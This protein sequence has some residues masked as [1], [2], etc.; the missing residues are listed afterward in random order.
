MKKQ[1]DIKSL[2]RAGVYVWEPKTVKLV[3]AD[4]VSYTQCFTLIGLLDRYNML[5]A[6][7]YE[8]SGD[9]LTVTVRFRDYYEYDAFISVLGNLFDEDGG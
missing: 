7:D 5:L 9:K 3:F 8:I 2:A 1:L 6:Y 4:H